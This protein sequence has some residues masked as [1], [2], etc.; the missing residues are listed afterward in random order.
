MFFLLL[1]AGMDFLPLIKFHSPEQEAYFCA[2][3]DSI[4]NYY[5]NSLESL[6]L[7]GSM[8][9]KNNRMNSDCDLLVILSCKNKISRGSLNREFNAIELPLRDLEEKMYSSNVSMEI[10][11]IILYKEEAV[12][13]NP[14]YLDIATNQITLFDKENFFESIIT[15]MKEKMESWGSTKHD[16]GNGWYWQIKKDMKYG[17]I[18]DYD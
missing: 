3:I 1:L 9:N 4:I 13:F 15:N 2:L 5:G 8:A 10:S 16:T 7:F 6:I 18:L 17:D 12:K 14:L 11:P